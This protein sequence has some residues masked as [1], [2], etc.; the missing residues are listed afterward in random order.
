MNEPAPQV[1][2]GW[3]AADLAA[4]LGIPTDEAISLLEA[5]VEAGAIARFECGS[6][7]LYVTAQLV[8]RKRAE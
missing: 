1:V 7:T 2:E 3:R 6:E 4:P 8:P 5:G